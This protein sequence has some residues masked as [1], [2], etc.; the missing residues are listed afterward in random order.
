MDTPTQLSPTKPRAILLLVGRGAPLASQRLRMRLHAERL[1]LVVVGEVAFRPRRRGTL[2]EQ[3]RAVLPSDAHV[4]VTDSLRSLSK[5]PVAALLAASEIRSTAVVV[6]AAEPFLADLG[7][8]LQSLAAWLEETR[9]EHRR[10]QTKAALSRARAAG[11]RLGRP[12]R[13]FG[14][15]AMVLRLAADVGIAA[16][17]A[18]LG[19]GET[20]LR[21]FVKTYRARVAPDAARGIPQ[22]GVH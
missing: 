12:R 17:A 14:D 4:V 16:A 15:P 6:S 8:T 20:T 11:R 5:D 13:E 1:G 9:A 18:Q 2:V 7:P 22:G 21:R 10:A 19:A 3:L